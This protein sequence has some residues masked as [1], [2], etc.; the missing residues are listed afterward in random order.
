M[1]RL[2]ILLDRDRIADCRMPRPY[3]AGKAA[4]KQR[5]MP[6]RVVEHR[7]GYDRDVRAAREQR[8]CGLARLSGETSAQRDAVYSNCAGLIVERGVAPD[9][10]VEAV[11]IAG[12]GLLGLDA[13]V[14]DG[15]PDGLAP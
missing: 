7:F 5:D 4:G 13:G 2:A 9:W 10:M 15:A 1:T 14:K 8:L 6:S 12:N 3:Q 11:H